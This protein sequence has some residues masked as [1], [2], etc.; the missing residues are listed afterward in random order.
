MIDTLVQWLIDWGYPGLFLSAFLAGSLIPFSSE[1]V[2]L[3]L[4]K[5][6]LNPVVCL[7]LATLGNTL[8]GMTCYGMGWAGRTDWIERY[9]H[10]KQDKVDKMQRFLQGKGSMMAFFAFLPFVGGVLAVALGFMR[11]NITLTTLSMM[12][13]KLL[14]YIVLLWAMQE[15]LQLVM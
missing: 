8:G 15:T 10:V 3:T 2:L 9:L 14:R 13:G 4:V 5:L 6:G 1:I 7:V 12:L 11:S